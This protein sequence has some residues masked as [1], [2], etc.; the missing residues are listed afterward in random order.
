MKRFF[1]AFVF[2]IGMLGSVFTSFVVL[3]YYNEITAANESI[4][5]FFWATTALAMFVVMTI[6]AI[7]GKTI[8]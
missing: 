8:G 5:H 3:Y 6:K 1:R 4:L 7:K 2:F